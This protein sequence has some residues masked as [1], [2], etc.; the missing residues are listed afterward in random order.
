MDK[1]TT[2]KNNPLTVSL[3][4]VNLLELED[5]LFLPDS[6]IMLPLNASKGLIDANISGIRALGL[7]FKQFEFDATKRM[8]VV[9][10]TDQKATPQDNFKLSTE[11]AD[12]VLWLILGDQGE[13][14]ENCTNRQTIRLCKQLIRQFAAIK[15]WN[16]DPGQGDDDTWLKLQP[17]NLLKNVD[18]LPMMPM[19]CLAKY[20]ATPIK[21]GLR[22]YGYQSIPSMKSN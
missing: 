12:N 19:N 5:A 22:S 21:N 3:A 1:I 7:V 10:H 11:R 18:S 14:A 2:N 16:I 20:L 13:W 9:G 6:S 4:H 15:M 8:V 17:A